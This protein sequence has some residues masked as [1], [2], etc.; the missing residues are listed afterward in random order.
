MSN[1][2]HEPPAGGSSEKEEKPA[3]ES[4]SEK[5][6]EARRE[7]EQRVEEE[8]EK[9]TELSPEEQAAEKLE[10]LAVSAERL[11]GAFDEL[12]T[13]TGDLSLVFSELSSQ[14]RNGTIKDFEQ[15]S[16][17]MDWIEEKQKA[18]ENKIAE[19]ARK[20]EEAPENS[21][22]AA[23]AQNENA[24]AI[25]QFSEKYEKII[26]G[27]NK[28]ADVFTESGMAGMPPTV[29]PPQYE[30]GKEDYLRDWFEKQLRRVEERDQSFSENWRMIWPMETFLSSIPIN[31]P[32]AKD[33]Y[34]ELAQKFE[35]R[36]RL[37]DYHWLY[38]RASGVEAIINASSILPTGVIE[39]VLKPKVP[40]GKEEER[41]KI[42]KSMVRLQE[43]AEGIIKA[44]RSKEVLIKNKGNTSLPEEEWVKVEEFERENERVKKI[45]GKLAT[46]EDKKNYLNNLKKRML[47]FMK[48]KKNIEI[49]RDKNGKIVKAEAVRIGE[50]DAAI[51]RLGGRL[52]VV[53]GF[54]ASYDIAD[55]AGGDF[56]VARLMHLKKWFKEKARKEG[57]PWFRR[58]KLWE[59]FPIEIFGTDFSGGLLASLK[60]LSKEQKDK[61]LKDFGL[62]LMTGTRGSYRE[63]LKDS[64]NYEL[65]EEDESGR[66]Y[67]VLKIVKPE[68]FVELDLKKFGIIR[69]NML[70]SD[71]ADALFKADEARKAFLKPDQY[72]DRPTAEN[73]FRLSATV[74]HLKG[75]KKW[76]FFA[77]L[78]DG[79][80]KF[81]KGPGTLERITRLRFFEGLK[82]I[83]PVTGKER[84][85]GLAWVGSDAERLGLDQDWRGGEM[86]RF[87]NTIQRDNLIDR[88]RAEGLL[89]RSLDILGIP[90]IG[91]VRFTKEMW[92]VVGWGGLLA[93]LFAPIYVFFAKL[94]EQLERS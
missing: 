22:I 46:I 90:G 9:K 62:K 67:T 24:E 7:E 47:E 41:V 48:G 18:I 29:R 51:N 12:Y 13:K 50:K 38:G 70:A 25:K 63:D 65:D 20:A 86:H 64:T 4:S 1:G 33:F 56:F 82:T 28:L 52:F 39:R 43:L 81:H 16:R 94:K 42:A 72:L 71:W 74:E 54:A 26:D 89:R 35:D 85:K 2:E 59:N 27:L 31:R 87:I 91:P 32:K 79:L 88:S 23:D 61:F 57:D 53:L 55:F 30:E 3:Q 78:A 80:I 6:E 15:L 8:A 66:L 49:R 21:K 92:D 73:F 5:E 76:A 45:G 40:K 44:Q 11:I 75:K 34:Q 10:K 84:T 83:D 68:R 37:H 69:E 58:D 60:G 93:A 14:V 36:R 19:T 17:V 77:P